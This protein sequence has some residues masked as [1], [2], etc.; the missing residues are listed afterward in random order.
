MVKTTNPLRKIGPRVFIS[1]NFDNKAL[2]EKLFSYLLQLGF[3]V[4]KEDETSLLGKK[5]KEALAN[6]IGDSEV[7][8][9]LLTPEANNSAW[10]KQEFDWAEKK[11]NTTET[12][13]ILPIVFAKD[14]LYAPVKEYVYID[15]SLSGLAESTLDLV[16]HSCLNSVELL[17]LDMESVFH[18]KKETVS[19]LLQKSS[20]KKR[21][22]VDSEGIL[23]TLLEEILDSGRMSKSPNATFF[24]SQEE[25]HQKSLLHRMALIDLIIPKLIEELRFYFLQYG[26]T[27][28]SRAIEA[29]NRFS[30]F[31]IGL[32]LLKIRDL[33]LPDDSKM[34]PLLTNQIDA[35]KEIV[36]EGEKIDRSDLDFGRMYWV[37][38]ARPSDKS[39]DWIR[40][41]FDPSDKQNK[42]GL[43]M[44]FP[45]AGIGPDFKLMSSPDSILISYNKKNN[46]A[47]NRSYFLS[48]LKYSPFFVAVSRVIAGR[49]HRVIEIGSRIMPCLSINSSW[50]MMAFWLL[51]SFFPRH[52]SS[53][54]PLIRAKVSSLV[55]GLPLLF[56]RL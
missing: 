12:P 33:L 28:P 45:K 46:T 16:A 32:E 11:R 53:H 27:F 22:I 47:K 40:I 44:Y 20:F 23:F 34:L 14:N 37:L 48:C 17:P 25:E 55:L 21:V 18:F 26:T 8:I 7:F 4:R 2:A 39:R 36:K 42:R 15:A 6:R 38:G 30:R 1:Y 52:F 10:I 51:E 5:L 9:P 24:V 50:M 49:Y 31:A 19:N 56:L 35:A 43:A 54:T 13:L 41:G 3:Q 29:I